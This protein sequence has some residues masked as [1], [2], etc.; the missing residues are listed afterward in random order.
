MT[1]IDTDGGDFAL[2]DSRGLPEA[3]IDAL[4]VPEG[5]EVYSSTNDMGWGVETTYYSVGDSG[6]SLLGYSTSE[7]SESETFTSFY[8][9]DYMWV[10]NVNEDDRGSSSNFNLEVDGERLEISEQRDVDGNVVNSRS[11]RFDAETGDMLGGTEVSA[12]KIVEYG[13]NHTKLSESLSITL[14]D[15]ETIED[16]LVAEAEL[17][18]LPETLQGTT[19]T[20][21]STQNYDMG[22]QTTYFTID[23][24]GNNQILGYS[25]LMSMGVEEDH[26]EEGDGGSGLEDLQFV[27]DEAQSAV[28]D[29]QGAV[30]GTEAMVTS[31]SAEADE[32]QTLL[33]S[34]EFDLAGM[35]EE[36][37][38][39]A[40]AAKLAE[41][42]S[43]EIDVADAQQTLAG[44]ET[45][46]SEYETD[47]AQAQATLTSAQ[48]A[49]DAAS[50]EGDGEE[51]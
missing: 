45:A 27:V 46:L 48:E 37:D 4:N 51:G 28:D 24:D 18:G 43:I 47:L 14:G 9:S 34:A 16:Y 39:D 19:A 5:D 26:L 15:G 44:Y 22:S 42:T 38:A 21:A 10:G 8:D 17:E 13:A 25:N 32:L 2:V 6:S 40:Y 30:T 11:F 12:G 20:Y 29:L 41:I 36:E 1:E 50:E 23:D 3:F 31:A 35:V 33:A 49:L 7:G